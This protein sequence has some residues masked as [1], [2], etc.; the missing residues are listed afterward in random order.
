MDFKDTLNLQKTDF[1]MKANLTKKEPEIIK[2]WEN[3]KLFFK[4]IEKRK[5][6]PNGYFMMVRLMQMVIFTW[7]ML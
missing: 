3:E 7:D 5:N 4:I 2:K 6:A 1:P